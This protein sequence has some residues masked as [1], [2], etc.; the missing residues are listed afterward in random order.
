MSTLSIIIL[1]Y[2]TA[3]TTKNCLSS[4]TASLESYTA[5][6]AEIIVVDNASSDGSLAMLQDFKH[7]LKSSHITMKIIE[8]NEN[9]GYPKGNNHGLGQASA[10]Y[11]LFL[12][13]DVVVHD[14]DW[15]SLLDYFE[16]KNRIGALTV[17]VNLSS[18]AIDPASHRGFPT[19]W[20][21][22]CYYAGLEALTRHIPLLRTL[23]GGYHMVDRDLSQIHEIDSPSGAFYLTRKTILDQLHGFDETF[24]MYGEDLDLSFRIKEAGYDI[25]YNPAYHVE[26]LK[27]QSGFKNEEAKTDTKRYFYD[28]MRIFY[29]KHY[30]QKYPQIVNHLIYFFIDMKSRL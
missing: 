3:E 14:V 18:G 26:H 24:F 12:N 19:L 27:Y 21:S 9:V 28:A 6:S 4:L 11:I 23:C 13:S 29:K 22:F 10:K 1:S 8:N 15:Q 5:I 20:R 17:R 16:Q 25:V 30:A 2:N 7:H